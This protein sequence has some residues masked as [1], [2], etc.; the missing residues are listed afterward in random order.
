MTLSEAEMRQGQITQYTRN[1]FL[2]TEISKF[3]Y[4]T[5]WTFISKHSFIETD[6]APQKCDSSIG[7]L[8]AIRQIPASLKLHKTIS[9]P[10][11]PERLA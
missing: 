2:S 11:S 6:S 10:I 9:L 4:Y 1:D 3:Q 8:V 7:V 5:F